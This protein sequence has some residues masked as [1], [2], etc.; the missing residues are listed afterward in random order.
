[1]LRNLVPDAVHEK[2]GYKKVDYARLAPLLLES[3][4]ERIKKWRNSKNKLM[5]KEK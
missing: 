1:M 4:K 2:D 5:N 3:I